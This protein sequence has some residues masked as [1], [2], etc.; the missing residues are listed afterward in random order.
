MS[1]QSDELAAT[2]A[3]Q[4]VLERLCAE[5][6]TDPSESLFKQASKLLNLRITRGRHSAFAGLE[7]TVTSPDEA[8]TQGSLFDPPREVR[9][10]GS[11][12]RQ[13]FTIAH[14]IAH[15][16]I[17]RYLPADTWS[18][19]PSVRRRQVLDGVAGRLL[20]PDSVLLGSLVAADDRVTLDGLIAESR[21]YGVSI[22]A[23][24]LRIDELVRERKHVINNGAI[25][26]EATSGFARKVRMTASCV[27][28]DL[29]LSLGRNRLP[30]GTDSL[31]S[32]LEAAREFKRSREPIE[33]RLVGLDR[34]EFSRTSEIEY[35]IAVASRTGRKTMIGTIATNAV[36]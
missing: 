14:E 25:A 10:W 26:L 22:A 21:R 6:G 4:R 30:K 11:P 2:D 15:L 27:P 16:L 31:V 7:G 34:V 23:M 29:S 9:A 12:T 3:I 8:D 32:H 28:W 35:M 1:R 17:E 33:I 19:Y 24:I 36:G 5:L 20:V 13:R 18:R